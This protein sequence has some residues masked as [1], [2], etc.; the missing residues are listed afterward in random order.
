MNAIRR[1]VLLAALGILLLPLLSRTAEPPPE[2]A[3]RLD[4]HLA[5][6]REA[7]DG[8]AARYAGGLEARFNQAADAGDLALAT[9]YG[10]EKAH[11]E[12]L[13]G[14]LDQKPE[15]T[16]AA[17]R[18]WPNL[19]ALAEGTP[20]SLAD[21]RLVWEAER[22]KI[23]AELGGKLTQ[24][25]QALEVELTK[26]RRLGEARAVLA[27]RESLPAGSEGTPARNEPGTAATPPSATGP[28][29]P[30]LLDEAKTSIRRIE[31][32][33]VQ[34]RVWRD[35]AR[36]LA[37]CGNF[38][39]AIL[40]AKRIGDDEIKGLAL[41][42]VALALA[43]EGRFEDAVSAI[44][45][46]PNR[47]RADFGLAQIAAIRIERGDLSGAARTAALI[48]EAGG[49]SIYAVDLAVHLL[50]KGDQDGFAAK[51]EEA[52]ALAN[53]LAGETEM[54]EAF[55]KIAVAQVNAGDLAGA[56]ATSSLYRGNRFGSP[57]LYIIEALA[58]RGDFKAAHG[59]RGS[60]GFTK[61]TASVTGSMIAEAEA[62]AGKF[63]EA[64][65]TA[66]GISYSD[67]RLIAFTKVAIT[68]GD[69]AVARSTVEALYKADH[70]DGN[71]E[72][73][74]GRTLALTGVLQ[75]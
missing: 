21:F 50:S 23:R 13:R 56:K 49:K 75:A 57:D 5:A 46:V 70:M 74:C 2:L 52:K 40:S 20:G 66:R 30:A 54:K 3:Q 64:R 18:T 24:D 51:I 55:R 41:V 17:L 29:W 10:Q 61:F 32:K 45:P 34:N 8:L 39:E 4:A 72:E 62:A 47:F 37:N 44:K 58:K 11:V 12:T 19:P 1:S 67:H 25:L 7:L 31:D 42:D 33:K 28:A 6:R 63:Q 27:F 35:Y 48:R 59:I 53:K 65:S 73:R 60:S 22:G 71:R 43:K 36:G 9:A 26:A 15:D 68:E 69:L 16:A 38:G 14:T